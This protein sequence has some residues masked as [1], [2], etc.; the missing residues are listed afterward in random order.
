[1]TIYFT[2]IDDE[3]SRALAARFASRGDEV[4]TDAARTADFFIDTTDFRDPGDCRAAGGGIDADAAVR[5][6]HENVS[7]PLALL[8]QVLPHMTGPKR[9][10][11]L[12]TRDASVS[13]ST[14]THGYGR[15]MAKAA[16][17]QILTIAKNSL[18]AQ[19]YTFRLLDPLSGE[20][21]AAQAAAA[22]DV[23]F[24]RDRFDDGPDNPARDDENNLIIRDALG[25]EI[26]W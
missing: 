7:V 9:I 21:P 17:H 5:S 3:F 4:T 25:R 11:F 10:C 20:L 1:M 16:L 22:A 8:E 2:R 12:T 14:A 26:P 18:R 15:N 19:G 24:T 23:Y 6:Y 13:W